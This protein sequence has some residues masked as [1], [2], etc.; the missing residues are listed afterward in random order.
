MTAE[1][2]HDIKPSDLYLDQIS[3]EVRDFSDKIINAYIAGL[4]K[5][6]QIQESNK[7]VFRE[8]VLQSVRE[9]TVVFTKLGEMGIRIEEIYYLRINDQQNFEFLFIVNEQDMAKEEFLEIYTVVS[10]LRNKNKNEFKINIHFAPKS[11][12]HFD[13]DCVLADGYSTRIHRKN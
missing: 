10:V 11:E 6:Q 2:S 7:K 9:S 12:E 13:Y 4:Y 1:T 5:H 8:R 3:F